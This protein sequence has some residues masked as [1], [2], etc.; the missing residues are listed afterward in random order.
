MW[1]PPIPTD[2]PDRLSALRRLN[3]LLTTPEEALD[4]ITRELSGIFEVPGAFISFI[5]EDTQYYKSQVGLP[6]ELAATRTEPR[7]ESLCSYVVGTNDMLIVE[8]LEADERFRESPAVRQWGARFYAGTPL[9]ADGGQAVGSLCIIDTRPRR[10]TPREQALLGMLAEGVMA[11]VRLQQASRELYERSQEIERDLEQAVRVQRHLLPQPLTDDDHWRI[12]FVYRPV[13]HLGGDVLDVQ[14]RNDRG[15]AILIADVCGHGTT[16]AL[17]A[18]SLKTAF[19]RA[20]RANDAPGEM[21]AEINRELAPV[22]PPH[23]FIT[24]QIA[25]LTADGA[26]ATLA[27]A[28]HPYPIRCRPGGATVLSI[29]NGPPLLVDDGARYPPVT[30]ECDEGDALVFYTDGVIEGFDRNREQLGAEGLQAIVAASCAKLHRSAA[31]CGFLAAVL[32][33]VLDH[34][35]G[36]QAD[37]VAMVLACRHTASP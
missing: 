22:V 2:E 24:A 12:G 30:F 37:D 11:H 20:S 34:S 25:L 29:E 32:D 26:R 3:I 7:R 8:D 9:R 1:S 6:D 31:P 18:A 14:R 23:Q 19:L 13:A 35:M 17:T 5:D 36:H 15:L 16:A 4:R 28:G 33:S 21:L 27:S 10:I